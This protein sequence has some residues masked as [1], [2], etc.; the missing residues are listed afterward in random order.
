MSNMTNVTL[1]FVWR[2]RVFYFLTSFRAHDKEIIMRQ[3][4]EVRMHV[5]FWSG[6]FDRPLD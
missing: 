5:K 4:K 6:K 1:L 3:T 2:I